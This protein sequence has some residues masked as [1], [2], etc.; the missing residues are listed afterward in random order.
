MA[1]ASIAAFT[2]T[3]I[4][5][6]TS[7]PSQ[8][9]ASEQCSR[10]TPAS[11]PRTRTPPTQPHPHQEA[12]S[13]TTRDATPLTT[14]KPLEPLAEIVVDHGFL[15]LACWL[16]TRHLQGCCLRRIPQRSERV[17]P[18]WRRQSTVVVSCLQGLPPPSSKSH[19]YFYFG[20]NYRAIKATSAS[21]TGANNKHNNKPTPRHASPHP[22]VNATRAPSGDIV[23]VQ[24]ATFTWHVCILPPPLIAPFHATSNRSIGRNQQRSSKHN[25]HPLLAP[26]NQSLS[27]T[28]RSD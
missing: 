23:L 28:S 2:A 10:P 14:V 4:G 15:R 20:R 9:S 26:A 1:T 16:A 8:R 3:R 11:S 6:R 7:L 18:G 12:T 21:T 13:R 19:F 25:L 27:T 24:W 22:Q 5:E 17:G